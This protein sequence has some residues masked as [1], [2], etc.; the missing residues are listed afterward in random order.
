MTTHPHDPYAELAQPADPEEDFDDPS[1]RRAGEGPAGLDLPWED[2]AE[3]P[4]P[5]DRRGGS[6]LVSF[7]GVLRLAVH[8]ALLATLLVVCDRLAVMYAEEQA[9]DKI[10]ESLGLGARPDVDIAGFPFVTQV[11]GQNIDQVDLTMPDVAADKV[12]LAE[13]HA[14]AEDIRI[15][16]DLPTAVQGAVVE[17]MDGDV[18][19]SFDDLNRELGASQI[20]FTNAGPGDVRISGSLPVAD[21]TV[22]VRAEARVERRSDRAVSTTVEDIR[23]DVPGL[24]TYRP[25]KDPARSGLYLHPEAAARIS[26]EAARAKELLALPAVVEQLGMPRSRIDQALRDEKEL[27][28]LTGSPRFL[29]QLTGVNLVDLVADHPWLLERAGIDPRLIGALLE[30]RPPELSD[31]LSLSFELPK[32][33]PGDIRLRDIVVKSEGIRADLTGTGLTFGGA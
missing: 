1:G 17:R 5:P 10:Q 11:V 22:S 28:R 9:E 30:M 20:R 27:S 13:V 16:G 33:M 21:R 31:R 24:F 8:T 12:S 2:E 3:A 7:H 32:S 15:V 18:L 26:H 25:G 6:R 4:T 14:R 29:H 23:L 19:L